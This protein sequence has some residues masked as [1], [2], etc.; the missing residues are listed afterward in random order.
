MR[1]RL[2]R[3]AARIAEKV[4]QHLSS[5]V[6]ADVEFTRDV[7]VKLP[8]AA[9]ELLVRHVTENCRTL[10]FDDYGFEES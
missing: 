6:G 5:I 7:Q 9:T 10:G 1:R 2:G 8:N 3:D 4:A